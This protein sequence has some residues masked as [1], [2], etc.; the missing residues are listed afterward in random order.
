[1]FMVIDFGCDIGD[2]LYVVDVKYRKIRPFKVDVLKVFEN[3]NYTAHGYLD[4]GKYSLPD[5]VSLKY[6][7]KRSVF[8]NKKDAR[9]WLDKKL[10]ESE[11]KII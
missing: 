1:M 2:I 11:N 5:E 10:K 9:S 6:L 7:N 8:K 4:Y 3:G